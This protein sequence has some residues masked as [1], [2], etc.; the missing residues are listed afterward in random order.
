M[1]NILCSYFEELKTLIGIIVIL[2]SE[3]KNLQPTCECVELH[4][5]VHF[6]SVLSGRFLMLMEMIVKVRN[7]IPF[8]LLGF[9]EIF[10]VNKLEVLWLKTHYFLKFQGTHVNKMYK[11]IHLIEVY[12]LLFA[13]YCF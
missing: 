8:P 12:Q 3:Q 10:K 1:A 13:L 9:Y 6:Q 11:I 2:K 5:V 4:N 7:E